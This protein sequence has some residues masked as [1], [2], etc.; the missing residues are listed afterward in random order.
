MGLFSKIQDAKQNAG[1]SSDGS[2]SQDNSMDW[3]RKK[4]EEEKQKQPKDNALKRM[5]TFFK[6]SYSELKK[7]TW[8]TRKDVVRGT[9]LVIGASLFV[10]VFL[11]A[12]D[13]GFL[14]LIE[15]II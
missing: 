14:K 10:A 9:L 13:Y 6:Q 5:I 3:K 12:F 1:M 15:L 4:D 8:P 11:G 2:I 7:V